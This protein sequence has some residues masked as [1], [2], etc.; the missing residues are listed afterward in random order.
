MCHSILRLLLSA[1]LVAH[2]VAAPAHGR[3][4]QARIARVVTPVATL[5]GVQVRLDWPAQAKQ[6]VLRLQATRADAPELGYRFQ[7]LD[8]Q[9]PLTRDGD[10]WRCEGEVRA[11]RGAPMRLAIDLDATRTDAR[12]A[13]GG[14]AVALHRD[15]AT[16]DLTRIDLTRVPLLWTQALLARAWA[17]GHLKGGTA[18]GHLDITATNGK[19]LQI[20]GPLDVQ[21]MAFDTP[22]GTVAGENLGARLAIDA[23]IGAATQVKVDGH[24]RGGEMLFGNAY[25]S[26]QQRQVALGIDAV[27]QGAQGWRFPRVQWRDPGVLE[28]EGELALTPALALDTLD[29]RARS[30]DLA[31]LRAGYLTGFLG[32]AG[33]SELQLGGRADVRL[34]VRD[35]DLREA[36]V[37]LADASID[38][39][40]GRFRFQGLEGDVRLSSATPV[41]SELRWRGGS[42]HGLDF[43][44]AR[45]PFTS[46]NGVLEL[47]QA[48]SMPMLGGS[49]SFDHLQIRPP[50]G[51]RGLEVTFGLDLDGLDIAQLSKALDWPAF[52]GQLTGSIPE[53]RYANDVLDFEG[54][55]SV[56]LFGGHVQVSSLSMERPFGVA[57][58]LS[59]DIAFENI[60]L[61][62]LTGVLGFGTITGKLDG[63]IGRLRLVDW[64]PVAFDAHLRTDARAAKRAG[65]RQRISQRAVQDLSS[66]SDASFMNSLQSQ[67]IGLFDDFGYKRLGISCR[68]H[69]EVCE[70]DGLGSV[71]A[72]FS[73]VQGSGVPRLAVVGF[74]RRVDWPTLLERLEAASTGETSPVFQ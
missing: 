17:D 5:E 43:G 59:S 34:Q 44:A 49:A 63:E 6:G 53:A 33:L 51:E 21:G 23:R 66:V 69:E 12:L 55:L 67:L 50:A 45:L 28:V 10:R 36:D 32:M 52:T 15:A 31:P 4:A 40:K 62:A 8:W 57:P 39:P 58:T 13:R 72:G 60:D 9:C 27:Q 25:V 7:S 73:I 70:M 3:V 2:A 1:L 71:G 24:L 38:D 64:Q 11:G 48:A 18:D 42:L 61:E 37:D 46:A 29:I 14:S 19:P 47:R 68:L 56:E 22:D 20:A 35:G 26:L 16:P 65:V 41:T 74:N 30:G 54:G